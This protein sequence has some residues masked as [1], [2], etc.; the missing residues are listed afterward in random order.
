[1]HK[2]V[3]EKAAS[4]FSDIVTHRRDLHAHP[5]LGWT[6]F[7]TAS[8][9]AAM[10]SDLG[11]NVRTGREVCDAASR[12]G[13]PD[14]DEIEAV[15]EYAREHGGSQRWMELMRDGFTGVV[16]ELRGSRPGPTVAMRFDMD[17]LPILESQDAKAHVPAREGFASRRPGVMHA[18]GHDAHTAIGV[19]VGRVLAE[20]VEQLHGTI[21]IILQ[22]AEEGT[23]GAAAMVAAGVLDDVDYFL[24][25][26]VGAESSINGEVLPGVTGFLATSKHDAWFTG[27]EAHAG[28]AP[29]EGRNALLGAA[30][31]ALGI[32]S[33]ARHSGG[34]SRVNVGVL[35]AG[36][37]RNIIPAD[38]QLKFELRGERTSVTDYLEEQAMNVIAGAA[39]MWGLDY[40]VERVGAAPSASS[41][42]ELVRRIANIATGLPNVES[43]GE[44]V[45]AGASDDAT[46]MMARVQQ[47]GGKAAYAILGTALPS[48]HHT[49]LFDIDETCMLTGV[50]LFS[51]AALE[52][53]GA[54][55]ER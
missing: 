11:W 45:A 19:G 15:W 49:P 36:S 4:Q 21:R 28:L 1:M 16:A 3:S 14:S 9:A 54:I 33:I 31:A 17:A 5:E 44:P 13:V 7:R 10:L 20:F 50:Q 37:G 12:M 53:T 47:R 29:Q 24:C 35:R 52:L 27:S 18:C 8:R 42:E 48:G 6:E 55:A 22:P 40:R 46:T 2:A 26:H 23:R 39:A 34:N 51:L 41:D 32:H 43:V 38:A 30:Q 25:P